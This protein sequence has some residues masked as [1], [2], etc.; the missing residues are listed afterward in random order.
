M[1]S[2]LV[3]G[4]QNLARRESGPDWVARA[5][6]RLTYTFPNSLWGIY[7]MTLCEWEFQNHTGQESRQDWVARANS[8]PTYTLPNCLGAFM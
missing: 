7:V 1:T 6:S 2:L 4:F 3:P 8:R 5:N